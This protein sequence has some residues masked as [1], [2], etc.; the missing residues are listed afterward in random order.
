VFLLGT[1]D[2]TNINGRPVE[3]FMYTAKEQ[4]SFGQA[5]RWLSRYLKDIYSG[6]QKELEQ[7]NKT[8][9]FLFS[10]F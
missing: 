10:I 7:F 5:F 8:K 9:F 2:R 6:L 3:I 4:G 1:V